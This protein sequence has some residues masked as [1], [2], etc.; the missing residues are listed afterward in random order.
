MTLRL[1]SMPS[2][3]TAHNQIA[4]EWAGSRVL[5]GHAALPFPM[6]LAANQPVKIFS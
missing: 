4:F 2:P 1:D 6:D 3:F 5:I